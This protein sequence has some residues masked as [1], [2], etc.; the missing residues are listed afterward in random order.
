MRTSR[1]MVAAAL[2]ATACTSTAPHAAAPSPS[3]PATAA[4]FAPW[5]VT[6]CGTYSGKGCAPARKL[7]DLTKPAFTNP[8]R[9]T[10]PLYPISGLQSVVLLGS[11][12]DKPFRS[13]T[14]L[15]PHTDQVVWDG[16][17]VE[18]LLVQYAAY[19]DRR[20]TEV[21]ID[22]YAQADDGSV[23]YF[24]EDVYDYE[25]GTVALTE[26]T[27]L[28]GRDGAP[29][30]IMPA[31]PR[32][33]DVY[34]PETVIGIVFEEVTVSALDKVFDGPRGKVSGVLV[35]SELHLDGTRSDKLFAP[36]YGE[37]YSAHEGDIEA[38]AIASGTDRLPG[39]P[40]AE[41]RTLHTAA[42]GLVEGVRLAEW[43]AVAAIQG[44]INRAWSTVAPIAPPRVGSAMK[45][46]L[47]ALAA[48]VKKRD[49]AA[50]IQAAIDVAQSG[51]DVQL[52]YR[53]VPAVDIARFHLHAQQ[54]RLHAA[55]GDRGGVT[56]EVAVL[57]WV[58]QRVA[59]H[60]PEG[61]RA[62][63]A[64]L[65][66]ELRGAAGAGDLNGA[67]DIA[68]RLAADLNS[69]AAAVPGWAG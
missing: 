51:I 67:G 41:L 65:L 66:T 28:A 61:K 59:G 3:P 31:Q 54:L 63:I 29:A 22:R 14:T 53:P 7:V 44:R 36:G 39:P 30:M 24:G 27:W 20:I 35:G 38:L 2:L 55:A 48:A 5:P 19:L 4:A 25:D 12:D 62:P 15:L 42:W 13:E 32:V 52:R 10:N 68:A 49:A 64:G 69:V 1:A 18:V 26:G 9:I 40:P 8:T 33:G 47:A 45:G 58:H 21:A 11:V 23:W 60:L 50:G 16:R 37:F 43:S 46:A 34:R 56:G 6:E 17:P 57:E